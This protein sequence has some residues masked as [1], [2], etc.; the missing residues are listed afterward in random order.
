MIEYYLSLG[1]GERSEFISHVTRFVARGTFFRW[2]KKY[3]EN[4][5]IAAKERSDKG[6]KRKELPDEVCD[7]VRAFLISSPQWSVSEAIRKTRLIA[8]RGNIIDDNG[9][10][11]DEI[12][13]YLVRR[14]VKR[15]PIH[16]MW[17]NRWYSKSNRGLYA[18]V[19]HS[20]GINPP[21]TVWMV[22]DHDQ[23]VLVWAK[24][25]DGKMR[26]VR[27][28]AIRVIDPETNMIMGSKLTDEHYGA[29]EI[30]E[31]ILDG[32]IKHRMIPEQIYLECD[33]RMREKGIRQGLEF[34]GVKI[35]GT[36][37]NPTAK[38]NVERSFGNDR[39][40]LDCHFDSYI[41]N[42]VVNRPDDA[43]NRVRVDYDEY[44]E[45]YMQYVERW[46][47]ERLSIY[48]GKKKMTPVAMWNQWIEKGWKPTRI[49][50]DVIRHLP[51]WFGKV[52]ERVVNGG[53]VR[54][55]ID[56]EQF[57]YIGDCLLG[58]PNGFPVEIR[59]NFMDMQTGYVYCEGKR[60]GTCEIVEK[61][62]YGF[63]EYSNQKVVEMIA[64][65]RNKRAKLL[66]VSADEMPFIESWIA[67]A[68]KYQKEKHG[69]EKMLIPTAVVKFLHEQTGSALEAVEKAQKREIKEL[70]LDKGIRAEGATDE[71]IRKMIAELG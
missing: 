1:K 29:T 58:L 44:A 15:R 8:E 24:D 63:D 9:E 66:K 59:R 62:G 49:S 33:K 4:G 61:L 52:E 5:T 65:Y 40:E 41:N 26:Q 18:S 69:G 35:I 43:E 48:R 13:D 32:I 53:M 16:D 22:D 54:F 68:E 25:K 27:P 51:Y 23:D 31:A 20:R 42:N 34:M 38:S 6:E 10:V 64:K 17:F 47:N 45:Q 67:I 50:G 37:Y 7:V 71:E 70:E 46:N 2:L 11:I 30:K 21:N 56:G 12:S 28:K 3:R 19:M 39:M 57:F 14:W 55:T 36:P 60:I